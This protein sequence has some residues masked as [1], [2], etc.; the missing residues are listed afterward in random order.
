MR[1]RVPEDAWKHTGRCND[2]TGGTTHI[3]FS[4][5]YQDILRAKEIC[6]R[7]LVRDACHSAAQR[8]REPWGVWGGELFAKGQVRPVKPRGRPPKKPRPHVEVEEAPL[9]PDLQHAINN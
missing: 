7:C 2:G 9:P 3:F 5:N 6:S 4:E 1:V 8:R